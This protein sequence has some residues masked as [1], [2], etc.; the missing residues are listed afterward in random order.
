MKIKQ[1]HGRQRSNRRKLFQQGS[2]FNHFFVVKKSRFVV[3]R[4]WTQNSRVKER[5]RRKVKRAIERR[6]FVN[7]TQDY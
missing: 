7:F 5:S 2:L 6:K 4:L 1:T 3:V